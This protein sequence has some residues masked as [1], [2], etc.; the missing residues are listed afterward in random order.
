MAYKKSDLGIMGMFLTFLLT[1]PSLGFSEGDKPIIDKPAKEAIPEQFGPITPPRIMKVADVRIGMKGYGKTVFEGSRIER[2]G[3][4]VF[5][6]LKNTT[7]KHDAILVRVN[8]HITDNAGIIQGMSGSPVYL[9]VDEINEPEGRLVGALAFGWGYS[10]EPLGGVTPIEYMIEEM[11]KPLEKESRID[12][13]PDTLMARSDNKP[14]NNIDAQNSD[15][16]ALRPLMT[17]LFVAGLHPKLMKYFEQDLKQFNLYPIQS[18]GAG[19]DYDVPGPIEPGSALGIP[20]ARGDLDLTGIGTV[21]YVEGNRL[22]AFGHY[23]DLVG[24]TLLPMCKAYI[25][26]TIPRQ[27]LSFKLGAGTQEI[28]SITQDRQFCVAGVMGKKTPMFPLSIK[29]ANLKTGVKNDFN[30][31]IVHH[32]DITPF[33]LRYAI[34]SAITVSEPNEGRTTVESIVTMK[35]KDYEPITFTRHLASSYGVTS[36]VLGDLFYDLLGPLWNNPY[37]DIK[38]ENIAVDLKVINEDRTAFIRN[39]WLEKDEVK[40]GELVKL[41]VA[42]KPDK[43]PEVIRTV[44]FVI[45]DDME[46]QDLNIEITSGDNVMPE[47]PTP[48]SIK[49]MIYF[50]KS[51]YESN[52]LITVIPIRSTNLLYNGKSLKD[53]P[54]SVLSSIINQSREPVNVKSHN[55]ASLASVNDRYELINNALKIFTETEYI[56]KGSDSVRLKVRKK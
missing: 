9:V 2:F 1:L 49:E 11:N 37:K 40:P 22:T 54:N 23:M 25:F 50:L 10:K 5:G 38:L 47:L 21:T 3:V 29:I 26:G 39:T 30:M 19:T 33:I 15:S 41:F 31:E 14:K 44:Q 16:G 36:P 53:L 20:M 28:G 27:S 12:S 8:H 52:T 34:A 32:K 4:E 7:P 45:P 48:T 17:P 24:E 6:I 42:L 56:L 43:K 18:G 51:L 55:Q 46:N 13:E 35:I